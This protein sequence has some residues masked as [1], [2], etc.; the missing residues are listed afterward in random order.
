MS[1]R[2]QI[3]SH[4][5]GLGL[6]RDVM[7]LTQVIADVLPD[8]TI[9]FAEWNSAPR[10]GAQHFDLNIFVE[11][12]EPRH[13]PSARKNVLI[14]NPEWYEGRWTTAIRRFNE[15][16]CKT[17]DAEAIFRKFGARTRHISFDSPD[18]YMDW[19]PKDSGFLHVAGGSSAKGTDA[20][21]TAFKFTGLPLT[22]TSNDKRWK[23]HGAKNIDHIVGRLADED[24][25]TLMNRHRVHVCP[26][27]YEGFGHYINE[28]MA[29]KAVVITTNG[30]PMNEIVDV[31]ASYGVSYDRTTT[32]NLASHKHVNV[33]E[34]V[35]CI[36]DCARLTPEQCAVL[37]DRSRAAY[38]ARREYFKVAMQKALESIL[39]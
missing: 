15:V 22:L 37:G 1:Y 33:Y 4:E 5:N 12:V 23:T 29:C 20:V 3:L 21:I 35:T 18:V 38:I 14:P 36:G 19:I 25:R 34:L 39:Q 32:Q 2:I 24:L 8:A 13:F 7:V 17:H 6:T 30:T 16:W 9:S 27:S 28:A 31:S 26:S 11:L 10:Y